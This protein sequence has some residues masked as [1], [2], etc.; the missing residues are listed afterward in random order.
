VGRPLRLVASGDRHDV[1]GGGQ[2]GV[3]GQDSP[4]GVVMYR[5]LAD[6][7]RLLVRRRGDAARGW[8][9]TAN[10]QVSG[11]ADPALVRQAVANA[12]YRVDPITSGSTTD[13]ENP[14]IHRSA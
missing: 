14:W 7:L 4:G 6:V 10:T 8:K 12:G 1:A 2:C 5:L 13:R 11:P 3:V 9:P